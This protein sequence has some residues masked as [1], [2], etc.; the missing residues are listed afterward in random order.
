MKDT[1][2]EK[3]NTRNTK[4]KTKGDRNKT[5]FGSKTAERQRPRQSPAGDGDET[6]LAIFNHQ[7]L[8]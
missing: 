2:K 8:M 4:T 3:K 6:L 1:K 7:I 5:L